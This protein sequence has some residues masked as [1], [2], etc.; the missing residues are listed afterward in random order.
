MFCSWMGNLPR[1]GE[2]K[3]D[4]PTGESEGS[5]FGWHCLR[6]PLGGACFPPPRGGA[7]FASSFFFLGEQISGVKVQQGEVK[8]WF[9]SCFFQ[10]V[11][12]L[13]PHTF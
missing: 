2:K 3:E 7:A 1:V 11:V 12:L 4:H 6:P 5:S 10:E 9:P 8:R 13:F